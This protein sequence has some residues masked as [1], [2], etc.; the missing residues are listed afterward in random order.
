MN[1]HISLDLYHKH[2]D[3]FNYPNEWPNNATKT[4]AL[5]QLGT[6]G[7]GNHFLEI[8]KD[9]EN[10]IYVMV[11]SGSRNFGFQIAN[12]YIKI[13]ID[14]VNKYR[15]PIEPSLGYLHEEDPVGQDYLNEMKN[16]ELFAF[17]NRKLILLGALDEIKYFIPRTEVIDFLNIRHNYVA[18]ENH[19]GKNVWVH[20]KGATRVTSKTKGIIPGS[21]GT[22]S[23]I[24]LGK[25]NSLSYNSCSHGAGRAM[26]RTQAKDKLD[27]CKFKEQMGSIVTT[28]V[29]EKHLDEAPDAYKNIDE[30]ME[31]Q[32][33]LV[34]V[35]HKLTPIMNIKG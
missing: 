21:M 19:F 30:V 15:I 26:S 8:Q 23:Y 24:V 35:V 20:R 4:E 16:A 22:S 6:L 9:E 11:H 34:D 10:R 29:N 33:D 7:S 1:H 25:D 13:A 5:K 2:E 32:K 12:K 14:F 31:N 3:A 17:N 27:I 28:C 18:K